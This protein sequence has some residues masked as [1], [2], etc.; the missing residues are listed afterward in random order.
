M[1]ATG[2]VIVH[3]TRVSLDEGGFG[4]DP[5]F[6]FDRDLTTPWIGA[7]DTGQ[8]DALDL[9]A[10]KNAVVTSVRVAPR[11][12]ANDGQGFEIYV[13]GTTISGSNTSATAARVTLKAFTNA[14]K[15]HRRF[16][17][18]ETS[19][20]NAVAYRFY[21][22]NNETYGQLDEIQFIAT[23][24]SGTGDFLCRP[25]EPVVTPGG[26]IYPNSSSRLVTMTCRTTNATIMY[27]TD[28]TTPGGTPASPTGTTMVYTVPFW[29]SP[30]AGGVTIKAIAY[31]ADCSTTLS[32]VFTTTT[33]KIGTIPVNADWFAI[34]DATGYCASP[35][36]IQAMSGCVVPSTVSGDGYHYWFGHFS[37]ATNVGGTIGLNPA[38]ITIYAYR[39]TDFVNWTCLGPI[40]DGV[41]RGLG[42]NDF[43]VRPNVR[44]VGS[45]WY[46]WIKASSV[47]TWVYTASSLSGTWTY[48]TALNPFADT[49]TPTY[50]ASDFSFFFANSG[51]EY[52]VGAG[53]GGGG[54]EAICIRQL[55]P[56]DGAACTGST[57]VLASSG[58]REAPVMMQSGTTFAIIT[59]A[60]NYYDSTGNAPGGTD[61]VFNSCFVL[62][63]GGTTPLNATWGAFPGTSIWPGGTPAVNTTYNCQ[64]AHII[65]SVPGVGSVLLNDFWVPSPNGDSRQVWVPISFN[66]TTVSASTTPWLPTTFPTTET[67]RDRGSNQRDT[68]RTRVR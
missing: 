28:G 22:A 23:A 58:D 18:R 6:A 4:G 34:N 48:S 64:P 41:A 62:G 56:S 52:I 42:T 9:G 37:D 19:F 67:T 59:S 35:R 24:G 60:Q 11:Q 26:G 8:Y 17:A 30:T 40:I 5:D 68:W 13:W 1:A 10:G 61:P 31:Q 51:L 21:I 32:D 55:D 47:G 39:S 49:V 16:F 7:T 15:W 63:T 14:D 2:E 53:F 25:M 20:A 36:L 65:K 3:G 57:V 38:A 29:V 12:S 44:K 66:G 45:T 43:L 46:M 33:F 50:G 54:E 27:T